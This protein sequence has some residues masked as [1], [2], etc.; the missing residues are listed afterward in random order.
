VL[1]RN[2]HP[3]AAIALTYPTDQVDDEQR[4]TLVDAARLAATEVSRRLGRA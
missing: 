4:L 2:D 1:D 3:V